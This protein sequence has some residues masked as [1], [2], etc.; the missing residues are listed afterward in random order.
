MTYNISGW[1]HTGDK[2]YYKDNGEVFII[3]R[4][5]EVLKFR[6]H[7]VSPFE[8]EEILVNH[9]GVMEV[10]VVAVP[11]EMDLERPMAFVTKVLGAKVY[12]TVIEYSE[13]IL[14]HKSRFG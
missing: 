7:H 4:L 6:G 9:P 5:K 14:E 2:G 1:L 3:D 8:I 13:N 10:A 11:H 12:I